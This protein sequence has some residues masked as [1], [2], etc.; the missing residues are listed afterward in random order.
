MEAI[1][2]NTPI[3]ADITSVIKTI[4]KIKTIYGDLKLKI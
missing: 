2:K 4:K 1:N 3:H